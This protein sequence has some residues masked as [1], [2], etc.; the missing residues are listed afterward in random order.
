MGSRRPQPRVSRFRASLLALLLAPPLTMSLLSQPVLAEPRPDISSVRPDLS[1]PKLTRGPAGPGRRVKEI[2]A[3]YEKTELYHVT[4]LPTDWKPGQKY[5]VIIELAG[6]GPYKSP[7][8]DI[9]TGRPE[10]SKLGYGISGGRGYIWICLP[11][12][13]GAGTRI[14]TRWW[15]TRPEYDPQPTLKYIKQAVPSLCQKHHGDPARVVLAGFSRGAIACNYIGLY[16]DEVARLWAALIPYSHYDG[17]FRRWGY[18]GADRAS[19]LARLKRLGNRPQ[20]ICHEGQGNP[21]TSLS[22]TRQYL[23]STGTKGRF[24]FQPTGF[25][26]HNDAWALRPSAARKTLRAWLKRSLPLPQ[27]QP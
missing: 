16:D 10:G 14:T 1:L 3:G 20:F 4:W 19:A 5:P 8:G 15:G 26:N 25:R 21:A 7:F 11:F 22:A 9:S 2:L 23:K 18:P 12:V 6:N 27:T 17:V 13:N 24:T